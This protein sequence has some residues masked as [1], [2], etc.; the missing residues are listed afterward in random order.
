[1]NPELIGGVAALL[2]VVSFMPQAWKVIRTRKTDQLATPMWVLNF[3]GF[4]LWTVYG[5]VLGK[6]AII[7]P[8]AI[9]T[10]LSGFILTMKLVSTPTKHAI[11]DA[12][13][14]T[15]KPPDPG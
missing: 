8:N 3:A 1:M 2:S 4:I 7:I 5:V 15:N 10:V 11:A 6:W 9:C 12:L 13:D 14:P